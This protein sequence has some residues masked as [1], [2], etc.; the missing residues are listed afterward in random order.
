MKLHLLIFW[1]SAPCA[2]SLLYGIFRLLTAVK[3]FT[4]TTSMKILMHFVT[5]VIFSRIFNGFSVPRKNRRSIQLRQ[6]Q[7]ATW[8]PSFFKSNISSVLIHTYTNKLG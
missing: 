6:I 1:C 2:S 8:F 7:K 5:D 4:F 3:D